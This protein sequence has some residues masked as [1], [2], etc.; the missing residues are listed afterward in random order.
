MKRGI[1]LLVLAGLS[2]A[3]VAFGARA[4]LL[5]E[6][7]RGGTESISLGTPVPADAGD[8]RALRELVGSFAERCRDT[9]RTPSSVSNLSKLEA[10]AS[11]ACVPTAA[12]GPAEVVATSYRSAAALDDAFEEWTAL[13]P[14]L[15]G[16]DG[17]PGRTSWTRRDDRIAGRILCAYSPSE[18]YVV[19]TE[20][21]RRT[22][23][24]AAIPGGE[25]EPGLTA[26]QE[27]WHAAVR[28]ST[29]AS[30]RAE[31]K[32]VTIVRQRVSA[33]CVPDAISGSPMSVATVRC[34]GMR[35]RS[36]AQA[37]DL[38]LDRLGAPATLRRLVEDSLA[39][40]PELPADG[41]DPCRD[42]VLDRG[43]WRR[44]DGSLAGRVWCTPSGSGAAIRWTDDGALLLGFL[45]GSDTAPQELHGVWRALREGGS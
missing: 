31:R 26:L 27:W 23:L 39:G 16:C 3:G 42:R 40:Q 12:S 11:I 15:G 25:G 29:T 43:I 33:R 20:D 7:P 45:R 36:G 5:P 38:F 41:G 44:T 10:T 18:D 13:N 24:Y 21:R 37:D 1:L 8:A 30:R 4:L 35:S 9:K 19:W 32:L 22:L 34:E 28:P 14:E 6:P 2:S 17:G